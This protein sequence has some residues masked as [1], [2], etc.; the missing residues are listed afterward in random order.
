MSLN[1]VSDVSFDR[2]LSGYDD[3]RRANGDGATGRAIRVHMSGVTLYFV[4]RKPQSSTPPP[5]GVLRTKSAPCRR[6]G[7]M[8][9]NERCMPVW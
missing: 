1:A 8:T 3:D 7:F 5:P 9:R 4:R 6:T 2:N